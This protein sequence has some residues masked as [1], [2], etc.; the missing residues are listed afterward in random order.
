VYHTVAL[1][2]FSR[3]TNV[4]KRRAG[5]GRHNN[6]QPHPK[7]RGKRSFSM[8]GF[9][10]KVRYPPAL[11]GGGLLAAPAYAAGTIDIGDGRTVTIG[12][13]LRA[14]TTGTT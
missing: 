1:R 8:N 10:A 13:G 11:L 12:A 2:A 7:S 14:K 6:A 5:E 3:G 9:A 4:A